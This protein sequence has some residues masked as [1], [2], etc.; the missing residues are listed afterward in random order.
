MASSRLVTAI[1][2]F[3]VPPAEDDAFVAAWRDEHG[4]APLFRAIRTDAESR[5]V[6]IA[7]DGPYAL[8]HEEGVLDEPD[9][10]FLVD[11]TALAP[12]TGRRGYLGMRRYA[13]DGLPHVT[14]ARWSSPLMV[15]RARP[16]VSVHAALYQRVTR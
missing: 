15:Q 7:S 13:A 1:E 9:G 4:A 2:F 6:G 16:A 10:V 14:I 3:D 5:F 11:V 12:A 8:V